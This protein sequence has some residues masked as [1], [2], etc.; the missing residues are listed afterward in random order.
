MT[1]RDW[2]DALQGYRRG[3][4]EVLEGLEAHRQAAGGW[5]WSS[6]PTPG[7]HLE[8]RHDGLVPG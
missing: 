3:I 4:E 7:W 2:I 6:R 8:T 1:A 5:G